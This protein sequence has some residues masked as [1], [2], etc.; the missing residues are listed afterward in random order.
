[1]NI[2]QHP[3]IIFAHPDTKNRDAGASRFLSERDYPELVQEFKIYRF[4]LIPKGEIEYVSGVQSIIVNSHKINQLELNLLQTGESN[5]LPSVNSGYLVNKDSQ[6]IKDFGLSEAQYYLGKNQS[7]L[8]YLCDVPEKEFILTGSEIKNGNLYLTFTVFDH[9]E[10]D[11]FTKE[12][13][14]YNVKTEVSELSD[15]FEIYITFEHI[16]IP[17]TEI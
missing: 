3:G 11:Y 9:I 1:M 8:L 17:F 15:S 16:A 13:K 10:K 7:V 12:K 5:S 14:F 4:L 2:F 6:L